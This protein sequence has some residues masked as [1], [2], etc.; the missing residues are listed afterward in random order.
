V[1]EQPSPP[2]ILPRDERTILKEGLEDFTNRYSFTVMVT[3]SLPQGGTRQCNGAIIAPRLVVTAAHCVC[4]K[5][6]AE[7]ATVTTALYDSS[8][9][10]LENL[11]GGQ[12][13]E[14]EGTI[15][16]H[17]DFR[18]SPDQETMAPYEADLALIVLDRPVSAT[19]RLV[20]LANDELRSG[21]PVIIVGYGQDE[22]SDST[23]GVRRFGRTKVTDAGGFLDPRG[24]VALS[25]GGAPCLRETGR[26]TVLVGLISGYFGEKSAFT[27]LYRHRGWLLSEIQQS[28]SHLRSTPPG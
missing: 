20:Q 2:E 27:N 7:S 12:Y 25:S 22:A 5:G 11:M 6:C 23:L 4:G 14:H 15:R 18:P 10:A 26:D 16:P 1:L 13:E 9:G 19:L 17:P 3:A 21:E 8:Q 28:T 24:L